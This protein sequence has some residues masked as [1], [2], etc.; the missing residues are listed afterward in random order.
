MQVGKANI[1]ARSTENEWVPLHDA[2]S[3]GHKDAV[4]E[5]LSLNA[6]VNPRTKSNNLPSELARAGGHSDCA[7]ILENYKPPVPKTSKSEWYHG[8]LDRQEAEAIIKSFSKDNGTFLVR[9]SHRNKG[10]NVLTL[11][12]ED[13]FFN[14]IIRIQV[15]LKLTIRIVWVIFCL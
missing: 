13:L 9:Y 2:A 12:N 8:T 15:T 6:P 14:Y 5:L 3:H 11:L 7:E 4:R 1:Q 10:S